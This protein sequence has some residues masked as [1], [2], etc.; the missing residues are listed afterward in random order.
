MLAAAI[1][2]FREILEASLIVGI[3]MAASRGIAGRGLWIGS[4]VVGGLAGA[5]IIAVLAGVIANAAGGIGQELLNALILLLAVFFLGAHVVWMSRHS[6]EL[7]SHA[8]TIGAEVRA[9]TRPLSALAVIAFLAVLREG[10]E[11]GLFLAG[12]ARGSNESLGNMVIGGGLGVAAGAVVGALLYL[13]LLR[14][15]LRYFFTAAG[16]IVML[17]AA[18]LA[19][20][21]AGFLVQADLLPPLTDTVWDSSGIL[22]ERSFAGTLLHTLV[23]YVDRPMG[24]QV[25]AYIATLALLLILTRIASAPKSAAVS[26]PAVS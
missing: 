1:I 8:N 15:P 3:V 24:I 19:S 21:A 11:T 25:V 26:R 4:G 12:I 9:G 5:G 23:G 7:A 2:V 18:G 17:L 22:S 10:A 6:R 16:V 20:Q 14:I 13:G